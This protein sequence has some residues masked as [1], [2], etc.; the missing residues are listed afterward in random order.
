VLCVA[1]L[2]I[3]GK[4]MPTWDPKTEKLLE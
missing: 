2:L 3:L 1:A 4:K